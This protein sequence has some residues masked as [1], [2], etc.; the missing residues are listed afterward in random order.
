MFDSLTE[1]LQG[2]L[3]GLGG[4]K[5]TEGDIKKA[6]GEVNRAL[7]EADVNVKVARQFSSAVEKEAVGEQVL[8]G[9]KPAEQVIDIVNRKLI[10]MLGGESNGLQLSK[11]PPTVLMMIGLQGSGKTTQVGKLARLLKSQGQRPLLVAADIYRPAAIE[12]LQTLGQQVGVPVYSEGNQVAPPIIAQHALNYA[13]QNNHN[14]VLIDTA[15][16][17][18]IDEALMTELEQM[19]A[20]VN[21]KEVMLIVDALTGQEAVNVAGEFN[22]RVGITGVIM[23]KMDGDARGGAALSV[24]AVTGVPIKFIGTGEKLDALEPFYPDRIANRILGMGDILSLVEKVRQTI[25]EEEAQK[26]L[27]KMKRGKFD[28]E[29]FLQQMKSIRK[30]GPLGS[31]LGMLPGVGG[32]VKEL[33]KQL[34]TPEAEKEMKRIEA[35]IL[36]M[37]KAERS[38]PDAVMNASRRRRIAAGSGT[39][40][41]D[42]NGLLNQFRS[43]R[44]MMKN[45]TSGKGGINPMAMLNGMGGGPGTMPMPGAS[46]KEVA[47]LNRP[48]DPL[49][50]FKRSGPPRPN[51]TSNGNGAKPAPDNGATPVGTGS[52]SRNTQG[53]GQYRPAKKKK[54]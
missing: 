46:R 17:L 29:D 52:G 9:L 8:S 53:A 37:T 26:N 12:Q 20:R 33:K 44:D 47:K 7:I 38:N 13:R 41:A 23:T 30:M 51:G 14:V 39:T 40:V 19:K 11:K 34:D 24:R 32:Q 35:I 28:L 42:V 48:V 16:R 25:S 36:S 49:K 10:E 1:K 21:P 15:G 6:M 5:L 18:Q 31:L 22:R 45:M 43:M 3:S 2:V 50:D 4:R 27:E 54:K